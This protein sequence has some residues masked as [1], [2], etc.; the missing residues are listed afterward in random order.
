MAYSILKIIHRDLEYGIFPYSSL[1][2]PQFT[3]THPEG[4][5]SNPLGTTMMQDIPCVLII[6]RT[7]DEAPGAWSWSYT[8]E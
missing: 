3:G 2:Q 4:F 5:A 6:K 7:E 8:L 1:A